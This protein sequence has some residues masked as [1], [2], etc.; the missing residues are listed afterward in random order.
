MIRLI[1]TT[2]DHPDFIGLVSQLDAYLKV[3]DGDEHEFY[4]QFNGRDQLKHVILAYSDEQPIGCGAFK[5]FDTNSIEI[6]RMFVT[7]NLRN[8]GVAAAVLT[9]LEKWAKEIS[10]TRAVLETGKRQTEAIHFYQKN[11]YSQIPNYGQYKG[12]E[13]SMCF[14]KLIP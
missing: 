10:Y 6:K 12:M 3:T 11:G 14:E 2:S 4:N 1:K 5:G 7:P 9:A 8:Q 13:N